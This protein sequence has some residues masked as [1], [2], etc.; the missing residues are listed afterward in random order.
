MSIRRIVEIVTAHL[1]PQPEIRW[2]T[3]KP[4]G[5]Q[6]RILDTSRARALGFKPSVS[7]EAGI[8]EVMD[9]YRQHRAEADQRYNVF[10]ED[11][12]V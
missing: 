6:R 3:S 11:K 8:A 5:D 9:W 4:A 12:L 1:D 2:D 7:I 10:T